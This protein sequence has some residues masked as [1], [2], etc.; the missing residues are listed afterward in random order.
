M[1]RLIHKLAHLLGWNY[2]VCESHWRGDEL[3]M[4]FRCSV[5]NS[6]EGVHRVPDWIMR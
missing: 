3:W 1:N 5:C 6:L 4:G 2:G